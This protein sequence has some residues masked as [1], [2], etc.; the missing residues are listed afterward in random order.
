MKAGRCHGTCF[1][2]QTGYK[3]NRDTREL[4]MVISNIEDKENTG[5]ETNAHKVRVRAQ[6]FK[7]YLERSELKVPVEEAEHSMA[8]TAS[9]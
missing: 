9:M 8:T 4:K 6:K 2:W 1:G 3:V 7:L 5:E